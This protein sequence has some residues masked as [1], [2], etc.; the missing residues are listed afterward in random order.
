MKTRLRVIV[1]SL[2]VAFLLTGCEGATVSNPAEEFQNRETILG[3]GGIVDLNSVLFGDEE[4]DAPSGG[5]GLAVNAFLW[6]AALDTLNF[7]PLASAD[8]FGGVIITDWHAPA[9]TPSERFKVNI[10]V[11]T[12]ELAADGVRARVF[13][14]RRD[15]FEGGWVDAAVDSGTNT[16]LENAILTRARELRIAAAGGS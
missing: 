2:C 13:R 15:D 16:D 7:L 14:Q 5:T 6:R 8:P 10:V 1:L 11:L 9:E 12:Q 4:E 3:R